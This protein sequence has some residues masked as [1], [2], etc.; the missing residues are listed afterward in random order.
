LCLQVGIMP[1]ENLKIV[2]IEERVRDIISKLK[3]GS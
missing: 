2:Y 1:F 3:E